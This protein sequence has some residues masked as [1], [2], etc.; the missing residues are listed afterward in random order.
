MA[1]RSTRLLRNPA[2]LLNVIAPLIIY[3]ALTGN[4]VS[5]VDALAAAA[6]LPA[7][8]ALLGLRR[9]R[10]IDPIAAIALIAL[11]IG[12]VAGLVFHA[13]RILLVKESI[14]DAV[15]GLLCLGSL[16]TRRPLI[17]TL[18]RRLYVGADPAAQA[19]FERGWQERPVR[20]EA[21]R[22]TA[23]WGFALLAEAG[24]RVGLS[25]VLSTATMVTV[26]PLLP[27]IL[28]GPLGVATLRL[29]PVRPSASAA[30]R[31]EAFDVAD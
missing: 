2:V 31:R 6:A 21:R 14:T 28:L 30:Q 13:G 19:A 11:V 10:R 7:V 22:T 3:R 26:S 18:R 27:L 1:G 24:L 25:Y 29:R 8:G 23:I 15:L 20:A 16:S 5:S 12:L 4:G 9:Q 17:F